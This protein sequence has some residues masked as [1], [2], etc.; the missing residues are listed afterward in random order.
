[1]KVLFVA[2]ATP[3]NLG[4]AKNELNTIEVVLKN[5]PLPPENIP[6]EDFIQFRNEEENI[7]KLRAL[8]LWLQQ[9][10]TSQESPRA[11]QEQLEHL[12]YEYQKYM[13]IQH[14]KYS[15]GVLS[16]LISATPEIVSSLITLNFGAALKS[17]FDVSGHSLSLTEAELSAPGREVSY[18]AKAK[19]FTY[20]I[21]WLTKRSTGRKARYASF[22]SVSWVVMPNPHKPH[23]PPP[24]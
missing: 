3:T 9:R 5:I 22:A 7:A 12:L 10:A 15:Q 21:M 20:S 11:I 23:A 8:R 6:W 17:I 4:G 18:I 16:T 2:H 1:M 14:K 13:E 19:K 24:T